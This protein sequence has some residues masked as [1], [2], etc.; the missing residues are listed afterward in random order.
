[1]K[2]IIDIAKDTAKTH[3]LEVTSDVCLETKKMYSSKTDSF[4]IKTTHRK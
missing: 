1:M 4:F 3:L 2:L